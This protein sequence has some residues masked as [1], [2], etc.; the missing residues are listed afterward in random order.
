M[1]DMIKF[2][3]PECRAEVVVDE[4]T[5][6]RLVNCPECILPICGAPTMRVVRACSWCAFDSEDK[7]CKYDCPVCSGTGEILEEQ[8]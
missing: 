8:P 2:R 5:A 4:W 3:C 1:S 6:A 7:I